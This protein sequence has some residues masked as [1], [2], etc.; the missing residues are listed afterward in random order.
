[1]AVFNFRTTEDSSP[2]GGV[3]KI[4]TKTASVEGSGYSATFSFASSKY[5]EVNFSAINANNFFTTT[6][7]DGV[8]TEISTRGGCNVQMNYYGGSVAVTDYKFS[9]GTVT[10]K[11]SGYCRGAASTGFVIDS[12]DISPDDYKFATPTITLYLCRSSIL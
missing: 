12:G 5:P 8:R 10:V 3:Y 4:G 1:M 2:G 11:V 7:W 9:D 6:T